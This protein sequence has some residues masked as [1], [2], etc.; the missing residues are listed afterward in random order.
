MAYKN[1]YPY[2]FVHGMMGW[3]EENKLY[4]MPYWGM[5]CGNQ[6]KQLRAEGV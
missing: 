3:G 2:I 1:K 5:V 6:M 4:K